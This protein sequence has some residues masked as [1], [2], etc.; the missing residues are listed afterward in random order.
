MQYKTNT[1]ETETITEDDF[2]SEGA[3][4][5]VWGQEDREDRAGDARPGV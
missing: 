1:H 4:V 3:L 2:R 5:G